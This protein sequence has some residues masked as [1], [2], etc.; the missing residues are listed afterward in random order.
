MIDNAQY[1]AFGLILVTINGQQ[2]TVPDDMGNRHRQEIAE[3]E[4]LGNV[5]VPYEPP[6]PQE[7]PLTLHQVACAKLHVD[8]WDVSGL[9]R[10]NGISGAFV[11]D[12]DLLWVGFTTEQLDTDY[13]VTPA[14]GV[15]K[16]TDH[17]EVSRLG[18]SV[19]SFIV[20]RVQ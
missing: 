17:L 7:E 12:V 6:E 10:S 5:I 11:L 16:F 18:L 1:N 19:V 13:I 9:E 20:E 4:A 14:D 8:F 3:W 15:A 2:M